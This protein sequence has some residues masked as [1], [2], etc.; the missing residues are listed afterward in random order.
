MG[1]LSGGKGKS[2]VPC[3]G[4]SIGIERLFSLMEKKIEA[5]K[6][7]VKTSGTVVYVISGQKGQLENRVKIL[8]ELWK[9]NIPAET[10]YKPNPKLLT[11]KFMEFWPNETQIY[12]I[13][14]QHCE[15]KCIPWAILFGSEE[16]ENGKLKLRNVETRDEEEISREDLA[17]ILSSKTS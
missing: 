3:V 2:N 8:N 13:E 10:S 6:L 4:V 5:Q 1:G 14:L 16:L 7:K 12:F 17:S 11:G 15:Q 9:N